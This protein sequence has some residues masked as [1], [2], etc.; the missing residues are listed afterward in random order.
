MSGME[1]TVTHAKK[2]LL[3][4]GFQVGN[5]VTVPTFRTDVL[6][7]AD[8]VEEVVR[9]IGY[10][11]IPDTPLAG[12]IPNPQT[13]NSFSLQEKVRDLL[14]SLGVREAITM[15]MVA[16]EFATETS[17]KL[18]NPPNP[19]RAVLR[20]VIRHNLISYAKKLMLRK[21]KYVRIFEIGKVFSKTKKYAEHLNLAICISS[22]EDIHTFKGIIETFNLLLGVKLDFSLGIEDD[23]YWAETSLDSLIGKVPQYVDVYDT[24]SKFTPIIEDI[25]LKL[26]ESY[27]KLIA[28]IK[29]ISPLIKNIEFIEKYGDKLTLRLTYHDKDKQLSNL[30]IASVR[31][32]LI[33]PDFQKS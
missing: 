19:D 31:E 15:S 24:V 33:D 5:K 9:L 13:Y 17:V 26:T 28:K 29:S 23:I 20:P 3:A 16:N 12:T 22:D 7:S 1:V 10:D 30:D 6:Q 21:Q 2:V 27:D 4:L 18:T 25:N 14:V 8:I 32:V 11:K